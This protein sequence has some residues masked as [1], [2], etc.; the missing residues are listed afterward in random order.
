MK[1]LTLFVLV[2]RTVLQGAALNMQ[3]IGGV[4]AALL[5]EAKGGKSAALIIIQTT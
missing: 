1:E 5:I 3:R 4:G 2:F